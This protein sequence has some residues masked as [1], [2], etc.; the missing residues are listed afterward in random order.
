MH[1]GGKTLFH[2]NWMTQDLF[3]HG[4]TCRWVSLSKLSSGVRSQ[5]MTEGK[6]YFIKTGW[7][8]IVQARN[9]MPVSVIIK[10][11]IRGKITA[12][13]GGKTLFH[14]NWM[15]QDLFKHGMTCR[16]VSLSKL[17]SGVRSQQ[18]TEGK[19]Y[20]IKTGWPRIVQARNDMPVSVIIKAFIRG[21]TADDGGKTLFHQNWMTQDL[22]KHGMTCRWV[23]LSKLS[24]GVRSQQMTEGK[25]YFIKTGWPRIVQ[26]RNDMPVSVII[27][28]SSGVRSQQMTEGKHYFI[29]TGWPRICSSTEWHA[30][31][32]HYQSFHQG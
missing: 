1:D 18:M 4:M 31:E 7:P 10:A 30:G 3:K 26:A 14:Q 16:W 27:K 17:S 8:R 25:H 24:S 12:D 32:C 19:H 9:D 29:K 13:D 2:Q 21:I 20:F 11:F 23:S 5:Q 28:A 6:H 22:F 15:T